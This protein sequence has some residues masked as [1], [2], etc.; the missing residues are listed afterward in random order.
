MPGGQGGDHVRELGDV[1]LVAGVGVREQ[2]DPAVA[3]DHQPQSDQPQ[4]GAFLFGLAAL[5]DRRLVV[6]GVDE[7]G[8]VGHVQ[9]HR[10]GVEPEPG[11]HRGRQLLLDPRQSLQRHRVHRVPEPAVIQRRGRD[12]GE[13][14]RR[15][16]APPVRE[17]AL[18]AR[19]DHPVQRRQRQIG[20]RRQRQ[21]GR[22]RP[23]RLVDERG[24][25]Q[26]AAAAPTPRPPP[27]TPDAG[28]APGSIAAR[29]RPAAP[30]PPPRCPGTA[31]RP[32]SACRPPSPSRAG[33]S[34]VGR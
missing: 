3:G 30:P 28:S 27:R 25:P 22:R 15:G 7:G 32:S 10:T 23:D 24:H 26:I 29:G 34:T 13:P 14:V 21:P 12:L 11:A 6:A 2:R 17:P 33:T 4:V 31:R 16:G 9:R 18:G 20:A 1:G 19:I 5:R 8:E